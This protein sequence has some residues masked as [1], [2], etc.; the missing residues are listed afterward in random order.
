MS[1]RIGTVMPSNTIPLGYVET[2]RGSSH[3]S[4]INVYVSEAGVEL[5][6]IPC[7][8]SSTEARSLI[9]LLELATKDV[10]LR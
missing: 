8:L 10:E 9:A 5:V 2:L 3:D 6:A 1:R 7:L 4:Q